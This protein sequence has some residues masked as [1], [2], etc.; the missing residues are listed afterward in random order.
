MK[1]NKLI[2]I[3]IVLVS[4]VVLGSTATYL[5][6]SSVFGDSIVKTDEQHELI[7][8]RIYYLEEGPRR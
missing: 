6:N 3:G 4:A 8:F 2:K 1:T 5:N 7:E